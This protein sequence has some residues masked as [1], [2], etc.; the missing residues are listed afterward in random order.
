MTSPHK[1]SM[2]YGWSS[3]VQPVLLALISV[4]CIKEVRAQA[5]SAGLS[6][7]IIDTDDYIYRDYPAGLLLAE[8]IVRDA[9]ALPCTSCRGSA[10]R[11]RGKFY[12]S[13]GEY[14]RGLADFW[15]A[16][17]I[18]RDIKTYTLEAS[19]LDLIANTYYYQAYYDS[20]VIYFNRALTLYEENKDVQGMITVNH[21]LALMNHRKGDFRKTIEY[22]FRE[23]E[24]KDQ[25]PDSE[26]SIEA[27][28]AMDGLMVDSLYYHEEIRDELAA[29][30]RFQEQNDQRAVYRTYRNI[31]KAYEQL[32]ENLL[33]ARN[34]IK[35]CQIMEQLGLIPEWNVVAINYRYGGMYDSCLYYHHKVKPFFP[36]MTQPYVSYTYGLLGDAHLDFGRPD[37]SLYYYKIAIKMDSEMNNRI[38]VTGIHRNLVNTYRQLKNFKAAEEHLNIGLQQAKEVAL[39]HE[40]NLLAEGKN[41]YNDWGRY[42]LA[43]D[44]GERFRK[45]QDSIYRSETMLH[46]TKLQTA[47]KTAKREREVEQLQEENKLHQ[48]QLEARRSQFIV[49]ALVIVIIAGAGIFYFYQYRQRKKSSELIEHQNAVLIQQNREKESLLAEIHHRVKNNLQIISSLI[50]LKSKNASS[51]TSE[52]LTQLGNRIF[53]MGLIHEKLYRT[54]DVQTVRLDI[55]LRELTDHLLSS[56]GQKERSVNSRYTCE[57]VEIEADRALACGLICN[58]LVTNS[59]KYAFPVTQQQCEIE[60]HLEQRNGHVEWIVRDNGTAPLSEPTELSKSFG[61]RFVEQLVKTRLAGTLNVEMTS[62]F[63][64]TIAMPLVL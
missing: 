34:L 41:L 4:V 3:W 31:G 54:E 61:L 40:R 21:N 5:D 38:M 45:M 18:A 37:S 26:H 62:G 19:L 6:K 58:E 12:W 60:L 9:E 59:L 20:A 2:I 44:Y 25:L 48:A 42:Q 22:L 51:E 16:L 24:L 52:T 46:L 32:G 55:Y 33:A 50:N 29:L 15:K 11:L 47:F 39:I 1:F 30:R 43:F 64:T 28:G 8:G 23:E 13:N 57:A 63:R 35:T 10:Y 27:F 7:R 49:G 14:D 36:R 53:T 17:Q 56:F